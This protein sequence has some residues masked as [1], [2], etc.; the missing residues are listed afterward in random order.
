MTENKLDTEE[1]IKAAAAKLFTQK[2]YAATKTRDIA[3]EA[4]INLSLLNYYFRSKEKLFNLIMGEKI[5]QFFGIVVPVITDASLDLELKIELFVEKYIE[6]LT[7]NPDLPIFVLNEIRNN[8][9]HFVEEIGANKILMSSSLMNQIRAKNPEINPV[10]FIMNLMGMSVFPFL[11]KPVFM[12]SQVI[13][14]KS[15]K[16]LMDERRKLIPIWMNAILG[17]K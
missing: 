15:F 4:G 10:H 17:S 9:K 12:A 6:T 16:A 5:R 11:S 3:E 7:Q 8:P 14:E 13:D 2:G 1:K